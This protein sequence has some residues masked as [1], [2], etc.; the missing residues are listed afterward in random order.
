MVLTIMTE[1]TDTQDST[2]PPSQEKPGVS[3]M[4]IGVEK[5][6]QAVV[7]MTNA[8]CAESGL[9]TKQL[10]VNSF[11]YPF[12]PIPEV[13]RNGDRVRLAPRNANID[14]LGHPIYWIDPELSERR[15]GETN[16]QWN[17]RMFYLILSF[18]M[19][20]GLEWIDFL[21]V[22]GIESEYTSMG[23]SP[24]IAYH[25]NAINHCFA[26]EPQFRLLGEGDRVI[27]AEDTERAA[28]RA[29][30]TLDNIQ[31]EDKDAY[32][33]SLEDAYA[34]LVSQFFT[35]SF[36]AERAAAGNLPTL[37]DVIMCS[38]WNTGLWGE[39]ED[40]LSL[41]L[42][43]YQ[44]V[45]R[46]M[47]RSS[48][49]VQQNLINEAL[50]INAQIVA[51]NDAALTL[52]VPVLSKMGMTRQES[53]NMMR[54]LIKSNF[55]NK[56]VRT[57]E[58]MSSELNDLFEAA[59]FNGVFAFFQVYYEDYQEAW[60]RARL[61]AF[62]HYAYLRRGDGRDSAGW[63]FMLE[64]QELVD[65]L[66]VDNTGGGDVS[67]IIDTDEHGASMDDVFADLGIA[68]PVAPVPQKR[69]E[70]EEELEIPVSIS[71]PSPPNDGH[72][73]DLGGL[74]DEI[75]MSSWSQDDDEPFAGD[76]FDPGFDDDEPDQV[77]A[78]MRDAPDL[79]EGV[80]E[81]GLPDVIEEEEVGGEL[82][83]L[84]DE[85]ENSQKGR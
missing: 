59:D 58:S 38:D 25:S 21:T 69:P 14:F 5:S 48:A 79:P 50:L 36:V 7:Q 9:E 17:V 42:E 57:N 45:S 49:K 34:L 85:L 26:D 70:E 41:L 19:F 60:R 75:E 11:G 62:N 3:T 63:P 16:E 27:P 30:A 54:F 6:W 24:I 37:K 84:L 81:R 2:A 35:P 15:E 40:T 72:P 18:G 55:S 56:Q 61:A 32:E 71:R 31:T 12:I 28:E 65:F 64:Y 33:S 8:F 80:S 39:Y 13:R 66:D 22:R 4:G 53:D 67:D 29:L 44:Q 46:D 76:Q 51:L 74:L 68:V 82:S 20:D 73:S 10:A 1:N 83:D 77:P 43:E 52:T 47:T 78:R 23:E